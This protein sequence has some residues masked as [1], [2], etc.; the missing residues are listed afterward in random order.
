MVRL[1][2]FFE[3]NQINYQS[4]NYLLEEAVELERLKLEVH[5]LTDIESVESH[6]KILEGERLITL[7]AASCLR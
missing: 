7:L 1:Q 3:Q 2:A 6:V 5:R 4:I